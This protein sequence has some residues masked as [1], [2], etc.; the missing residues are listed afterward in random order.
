M[1]ILLNTEAVPISDAS[2]PGKWK[3]TLE[4]MLWFRGEPHVWPS[5]YY[6]NEVMHSPQ[7]VTLCE[8]TGGN[9]GL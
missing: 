2:F 9:I 1:K 5:K 3:Q 6:T 7:R 8:A 4:A